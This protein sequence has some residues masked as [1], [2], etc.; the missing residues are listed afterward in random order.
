MRLEAG[1]TT[2]L[3]LTPGHTATFLVL[4]GEVRV[5]GPNS[6]TEQVREAELAVF[7]TEGSTLQIEASKASK[8]LILSGEPLNEPI[9]GYGPFVMNTEQEIRQAFR[10]YQSGR[11]GRLKD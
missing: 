4:T 11:M 3:T 2:R 8:I 6:G 5:L 7:E 1:K 9:V 10:D